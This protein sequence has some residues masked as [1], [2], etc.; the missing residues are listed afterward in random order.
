[1]LCRDD[2]RAINELTPSTLGV[3]LA[4]LESARI[5]TKYLGEGLKYISSIFSTFR[6]SGGV[7]VIE[8]CDVYTERRGRAGGGIS[9]VIMTEI[10][11]PVPRLPGCVMMTTNFPENICQGMIRRV[12]ATV[13]VAGLD[14]GGR[15]G[16]VGRYVLDEGLSGE[17]VAK[18]E[19]WGGSDVVKL[20]ERSRDFAVESILRGWDIGKGEDWSVPEGAKDKVDGVAITCEDLRKAWESMVGQTPLIAQDSSGQEIAKQQQQQQPEDDR[21]EE[22][23]SSP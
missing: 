14:K 11:G 18:T 22:F 16:I 1:M 19:G 20:L 3:T 10:E 13:E 5:L 17:V 6:E 23:R 12:T 21:M 8:E 4:Y 2:S 9:E 15:Q 7:L